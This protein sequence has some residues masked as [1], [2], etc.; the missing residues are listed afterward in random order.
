[1]NTQISIKESQEF[2]EDEVDEI[3]TSGGAGAYLT[4]YAF[5]KKGKKPNIKAYT[6]FRI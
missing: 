6:E 5:R 4:P 3:S 2:S 1:M